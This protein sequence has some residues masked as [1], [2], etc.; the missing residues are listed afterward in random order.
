MSKDKKSN[1]PALPG[2]A[3]K[4]AALARIRAATPAKVAGT[5]RTRTAADL[6]VAALTPSRRPRLVFAFDA[7]ASREPAWQ[8]AKQVT[9]SLFTV[10]PG[11]LD[12]A[13]AVHGGGHV[14][15]FT[16][17]SSDHHA[18]RDQAASVN[19]QAGNTALVPLMERVL[20]EPAVKTLLYIGDCF[21]ESPAAAYELADSF[22]ARGI[23]A[24]ILHDTSTGGAS[25]RVVFEEIARRT[26]GVCVDFQSARGAGQDLR[27]VLA[28]VAVLAYGGV[29]LLEQRKAELPGAQRLLPYLKD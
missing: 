9:D 7:T 22:K 11:E 1:L 4:S 14:H 19:C 27:E 5:A 18:F 16:A 13:L 17:F 12:I 2:Q 23:K 29:K 25:A 8:V 15:T 24:F 6:T 3:K 10:V 21:E 26:G 20:S 28:A